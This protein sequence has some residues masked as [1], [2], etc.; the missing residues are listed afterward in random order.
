MTL[1]DRE[2]RRE[3]ERERKREM[4]CV[5]ERGMVGGERGRSLFAPFFIREREDEGEEKG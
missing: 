1:T 4:E 5:T 2:E 3:H